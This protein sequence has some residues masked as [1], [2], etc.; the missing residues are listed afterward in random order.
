MLYTLQ[1]INLLFMDHSFPSTGNLT[2]F[3]MGDLQEAN[4]ERC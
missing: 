1:N 3:E 4:T 2:E